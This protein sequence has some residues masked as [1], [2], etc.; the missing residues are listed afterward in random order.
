MA[1]SETPPPLFG[2]YYREIYAK[3]ML[4]GERP[5]LPI[6]WAELEK[7]TRESLDDRATAYVF[8]GAGSEDTMRA[9]LEAFRRWRIVPR[10][11]R[12]DLSVRDLS[13]EL[14][15]TRMPAP[16]LLAPI[17]MQTLLHDD[18][19][20]AVARAAAAIGL[21]L[22]TSTVAAM[23]L[24]E[25]AEANGDGPRW[26]QLYWPNDDELAA[27]FVRR[28][29]AAGYSAIVLTVDNCLPGWKPRDLQEAYLPA[30]EGRGIAHYLSDPVFRSR[31]EKPPEEDTGPAIGRFLAVFANPGLTW[32][33]LD[34][35]RGTTSLPIVLKGILHPDDARE[36]RERGVDGIVV[37]NHGGRQIDGAIS[38]LDALPPIL[39]AVGDGMA[40]LLDSGIRSGADVFK[41]LALGA[42]AVLLGRPY[43]WGLALAGQEGVEIVLRGLLAELDLTMTLSGFTTT[44]EIDRGVL[45][46]L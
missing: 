9:N 29:E 12:K 16:V 43:L 3:G 31:L 27:S 35:L 46:Q 30:L 40:V 26:F 28:A 18:G 4:A 6:A 14:L 37:S 22:I 41:A 39:D 32:E 36:A 7:R 19:E 1:A 20:L 42:D 25:I 38:S 23:P 10:V 44:G 15:G 2:D 17:G 24:E 45:R 5:T 8:G 21:P 13:L 34:W 11:L 33:R